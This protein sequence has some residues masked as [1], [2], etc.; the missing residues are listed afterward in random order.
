[1]SELV[2][3]VDD[4]LGEGNTSTSPR[5]NKKRKL[6]R[7]SPSKRWII[8]LNNWT[9]DN[10]VEL[11]DSFQQAGMSYILGKEIAETGTPHLQ[12]YVESETTFRPMEK[13]G[14]WKFKPHWEK[15]KGNQKQNLDYCS[16][17]GDY[18]TNFKMPRKLQLPACDLPWQKDI[19]EMVKS[20]PDDRSIYW[21]WSDKGNIGKTTFGKYLC[22]NH[23]A[24]LLSGK[25]AD[26]RNGALTW[27]NDKGTYP[28]LCIFPIPRSFN[29]DYLSYEAIENVKDAF[30]YSG[31]YEGGTVCDPCPHLI[32]FANFEP[33]RDK[34]SEDRW[35]VVNID[36]QG[37]GQK[38][39]PVFDLPITAVGSG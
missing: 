18:V 25:G 17:D 26:V 35:H 36:G 10:L 13:F 5:P 39:C 32:V 30:F 1:M 19:I 22:V 29:S 15:C 14:T 21:Y 28:D 37:P 38:N 33:D 27:K 16:K 3:L 2:E 7:I 9:E 11:V 4:G 24:C 8:V 20:E 34:M 6:N 23:N 31:K 12:G